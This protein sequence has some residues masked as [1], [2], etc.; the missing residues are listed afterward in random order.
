MY[1]WRFDA[2]CAAYHKPASW[3]ISSTNNA[4]VSMATSKYNTC[5]VFESMSHTP[6]SLICYGLRVK[7]ISNENLK[8]LFA[9]LLTETYEIVEDWAGNLCCGINLVRNY[10]KR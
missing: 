6:Y 7:Y 10:I 2:A 4:W 8:H 9:A 1:T 3:Q 5:P